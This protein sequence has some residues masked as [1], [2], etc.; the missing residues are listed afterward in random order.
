MIKEGETKPNGS[1]T[2][3]Q[4]TEILKKNLPQ[5]SVTDISELVAA[6]EKEQPNDNKISLEKLFSVVNGI[7]R[8]LLSS[9][10][11]CSR[12]TKITMAN[13]FESSNDNCKKI[14]NA[15]FTTFKRRSRIPRKENLP[16]SAIL[17]SARR[18]RSSSVHAKDMEHAIQAVH[19]NIRPNELAPIVQW[20]F[21][22]KDGSQTPSMSVQDVLQRLQNGVFYRQHTLS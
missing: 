1:V 22:A 9:T 2:N 19:A 21:E 16:C 15:T 13:S 4:F 18:S 11:L 17:F 20:T 14:N 10:I 6:A 7:D 8:R 12:T 5:K 3:D